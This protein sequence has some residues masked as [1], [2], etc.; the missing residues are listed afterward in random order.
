MHVLNKHHCF[1][2]L[3]LKRGLLK[4]LLKDSKNYLLLEKVL[5][6]LK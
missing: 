1:G 3:A 4:N 5:C 6:T 2:K